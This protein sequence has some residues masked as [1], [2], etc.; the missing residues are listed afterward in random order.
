[1]FYF[2]LIMV[3]FLAIV[4]MAT[5]SLVSIWFVL[6]AILAMISTF[7]TDSITIQ[8]AIFVIFGLIFMLL[9]RKIV[10]KIVPNKVKTNID[11][12]VGM[13][14]IVTKEISKNNP[15]EVKVD[16]KLWTAISNKKIPSGSTVKILEIN[17]TKLTVE[18]MEEWLY[19][20]FYCYYYHIIGNYYS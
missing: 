14:G 20:N 1:M 8:I 15:G 6:S 18:R 2:W 11:R 19:G 3:I 17:S 5:V 9:T 12:I 13:E 10:K 16:G 7:I 4:E